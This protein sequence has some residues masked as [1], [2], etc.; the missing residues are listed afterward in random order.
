[1]TAA[2]L[3]PRADLRRAVVLKVAPSI[4]SA[5]F[6][7]LGA[8]MEAADKAG[9]D[10][11]H[12]DV[13][14]GRFVP[15]LTIGLPVLESIRKVTKKPLDLHLMILE[16]ERYVERFRSAGADHINVHVEATTH[17]HRTL[18]LIRDAG[19]KA[20]AVLN[21]ATPLSAVEHVIGDVDQLMLM[22]V[23]PGFGGQ[24]FIESVVPKIRAAKELLKKNG[25]GRP[26]EIVIDGGVDP[27]TARVIEKAGATVAVAGNAVFKAPDYGSAIA[28]IRGT[29]RKL[30][31]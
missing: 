31:A 22:T 8:E 3:K 1:M 15:N 28:A 30:G 29:Q 25:A 11:F 14:D 18:N 17:L 12:V 2:G 20:G 5:D 27:V 26:L 13:M 16:P 9:A 21:P 24:K 4:L 19:A 7:R 23:N 10:W 6:A